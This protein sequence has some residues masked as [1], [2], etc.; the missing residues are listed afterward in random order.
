MQKF[1]QVKLALRDWLTSYSWV[2]FLMPYHLY[3]LFGGLGL[4]YLYD[5]VNFFGP[6]IRFLAMLSSV[7]YW[8]FLLGALLTLISFNLKYLPYAFFAYAFIY[9]F[10]SFSLSI[11]GI[12]R[13]FVFISIG[14]L[15]LRYSAIEDTDQSIAV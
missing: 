9:L 8:I 13:L 14:I 3:L 10:P 4:M 12:I 6:Y 1:T 5:F 7:G 2:N 15:L 11:A